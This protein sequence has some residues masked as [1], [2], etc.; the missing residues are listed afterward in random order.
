[1]PIHIDMT[2]VSEGG[3]FAVLEP[4]IYDAHVDKIEMSANKGQSGYHYLTF[5]Y[6]TDDSVKRNIWSNYSLSPQALWRLKLDLTRLGVEIPDGEFDFEPNDVVGTKCR[7]R[8]SKKP[9][10]SRPGEEDNELEEVL[11]PEGEFGWTSSE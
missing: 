3:T 5:V 7:V 9:H 10:Y 11:P 6:Q 4:G 8:V 1:M 2:G